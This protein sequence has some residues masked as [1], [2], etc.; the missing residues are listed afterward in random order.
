MT[1]PHV[2]ILGAGVAGLAAALQLGRAG[3][4]VTIAERASDLRSD[5]YMIG[6]SGPGLHAVDKLGLMPRLRPMGRDIGEN[7]YRD[8]AG[9]ELIRLRYRD[10]LRG[11][12]WLTLARTELVA[13][14]QEA[15]A[16]FTALRLGT[17]LVRLEQDEA[18]VR[19]WLSD[20]SMLE[21]DL[22]IGA[23]GARSSLGRQ[24]FG[25]QAG[26]ERPLGYR[27]AAFRI[28]DRLGLGED[29]LSY[30]EPG[31]VAET[32]QLADGELATLYVW[33]TRETGF[34]PSTERRGVLR[35][36]FRGAH[37]DTLAWIDALPKEAPI[38]LDALTM[39]DRPRWSQG[40]AVL[41]GDA[42]HCLTLVSGQGAGMA[43]ASA[44]LLAQE[45]QKGSV[46]SALAR[47]EAKLRPSIARLQAHSQ[48]TAS[49]F[50]PR[51]AIGFS[52][53][54]AALR[55]T[56]RWLLARHFTGAIRREQALLGDQTV[57]IALGRKAPAAW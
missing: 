40:R 19:A 21:A 12:D 18:K 22:L 56:P 30:V 16:P 2:L 43:M 44:C 37:P 46:I 28:P 53:R 5:G 9:R 41:L 42:A 39:I 11:I 25:E 52:L 3:W 55:Y 17:T 26:F 49:W 14:L 45:L 48:K 33:R 23:D 51:S 34:V 27:A 47:H 35:A 13:L 29:F 24:L 38:Y 36:A 7:V 50:V 20:G 54:N 10:L 6:L 15:A 57:F 31:R 4:Q 32:Y 8:R 1:M